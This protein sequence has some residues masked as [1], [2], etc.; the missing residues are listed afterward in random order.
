MRENSV[1]LMAKLFVSANMTRVEAIRVLEG[2]ALRSSTPVRQILRGARIAQTHGIERVFIARQVA[3]WMSRVEISRHTPEA[4]EG[5]DQGGEFGVREGLRAET[6][7]VEIARCGVGQDSP[8]V[9][10]RRERRA[11]VG[12]VRCALN[13]FEDFKA[14]DERRD[15]RLVDLKSGAHLAKGERA[16]ARVE[17]QHQRLVPGEREAVR[18]ELLVQ[19][20]QENLM[21]AHDRGHRR[22]RRCGAVT[23]VRAPLSGGL[24]DRVEGEGARHETAGCQNASVREVVKPPEQIERR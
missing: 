16:L 23:P 21:G 3:G 18:L 13:E 17:E 12:G 11:S 14:V 19:A 20:R 22:H 10:D 8:A 5:R 6:Y 24:F 9:G 7:G 15:A 1:N 4:F 2:S